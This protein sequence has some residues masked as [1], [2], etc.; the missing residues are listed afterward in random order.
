MSDGAC[1]RIAGRPIGR[2]FPPYV[3][4]ELSGN[5]GG[6]LQGALALLEAAAAA[7]A[8]AVKLQT[9]TPDTLTIAHDG[10][11][12]TITQGLWAGRTLH[13]LY[14]EAHTPF[15]WHRPLFDRA[16]ELGVAIFSSPF[17]ETAIDLL[18]GLDA[19]A[20][21]IASFE[22]VDLPLIARAAATGKPLILST[23][24]A[25]LGEI[26]EAVRTAREH[27]AGG[28]IALHCVS[29]YP[30]A[31]EDANLAVIAHLG[32]AFDVVAGLSDHTP[33]TAAAV[34][35]VALGAA[36]V[37]KH[38]CLRRADGGVDA[39]FSLEP[40]E[41]ERLVRDCRAAHA[42]VGRVDYARGETERG[43]KVY[44][45]S[46]YAVAPIAAGETLSAANVRSIRPGYGLAPRHLPAVLGRRARRAIAY[47][48]PLAW[49]ML[50]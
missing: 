1:V 6:T 35:A 46:L 33:G 27:G 23:G 20:Y 17:D 44:R 10:P 9:Y 32:A 19:P 48:E 47:G 41:L 36:F 13:D 4:G 49:D 50:A 28:V 18:E 42:A 15:A 8:D 24:M 14:A 21:K 16:R 11:G 31:Y 34:A 40:A 5:H 2:G 25:S 45:R 7:G 29:A 37:E 26:G 3:V 39:E 43:S 38:V 30:A 22:I 12:F